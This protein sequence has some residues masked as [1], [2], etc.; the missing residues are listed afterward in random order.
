MLKP[1]LQSLIALGLLA[2][3]CGHAFADTQWTSPGAAPRPM[4]VGASAS[5]MPFRLR[6]DGGLVLIRDMRAGGSGGGCW[7]HCYVSYDECL[8]VKEKAICVARIKTC[9]ETC[10]RLSGL[11]NPTQR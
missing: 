10:D 6:P 8:G 5:P 11:S 9:M 4:A 7:S 1:A 3:L 2:G